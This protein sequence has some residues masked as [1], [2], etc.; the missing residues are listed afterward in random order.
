[1]FILNPRHKRRRKHRV[2][3][4]RTKVCY[5]RKKV[6]RYHNKRIGWMGLVKR[7][8]VKGAKRAWR[9]ARKMLAGR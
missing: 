1:M 4:R 5:L 2:H 3:H 6:I 9:K 8:G 7:L